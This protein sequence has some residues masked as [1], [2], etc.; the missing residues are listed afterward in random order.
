[1]T[2]FRTATIREGLLDLVDLLRAAED[3]AA[4]NAGHGRGNG[5]A[6]GNGG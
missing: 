5:N 2:V 1:M 6:N 4:V 3:V